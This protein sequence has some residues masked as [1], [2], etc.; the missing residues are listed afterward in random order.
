MTSTASG[1]SGLD[2]EDSFGRHARTRR[3]T[4]TRHPHPSSGLTHRRRPFCGHRS[5]QP[6][7]S[8]CGIAKDRENRRAPRFD[9]SPT[10]ARTE[11]AIGQGKAVVPSQAGPVQR[12]AKPTEPVNW[13]GVRQPRRHTATLFVLGRS[14]W[15]AP[16]C[17]AGFDHRQADVAV[18][19]GG[20]HVENSQREN[21]IMLDPMGG[22]RPRRKPENGE[23]IPLPQ[24]VILAVGA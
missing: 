20:G 21:R 1:K 22:T 8:S 14:R 19:V 10:A 16:A 13:I 5:P 3:P 2:A 24:S 12:I 4:F 6:K 11:R 9:D 7:R 17:P 18:L 23:N 15:S